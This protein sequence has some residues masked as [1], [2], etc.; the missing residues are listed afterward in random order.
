MPADIPNRVIEDLDAILTAAGKVPKSQ[1]SVIGPVVVRAPTT[2][3]CPGTDLVH[4]VVLDDDPRL[5]AT[6][7]ELNATHRRIVHVKSV[8]HYVGYAT[9]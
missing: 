1:T 4:Q 3:A 5:G 8:D 6:R 2:G 9:A 7:L